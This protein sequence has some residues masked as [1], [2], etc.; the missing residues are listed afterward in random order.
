M[1]VAMTLANADPPAL[2]EGSPYSNAPKAQQS[3]DTS[4]P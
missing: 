1:L 3:E 4:Q 2:V